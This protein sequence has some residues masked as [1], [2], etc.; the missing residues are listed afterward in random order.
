M[1]DFRQTVYTFLLFLSIG[2]MASG[3]Q[4]ERTV[5]LENLPSGV[6]FNGELGEK[7]SY[8]ESK[9]L[10][11]SKGDLTVTDR[12]ALYALS[13]DSLYRESVRRLFEWNQ[14]EELATKGFLTV[15]QDQKITPLIDSLA[16]AFNQYYPF[17]VIETRVS[18]SDDGAAQRLM[19]GEVR[20]AFMSRMLTEK[21]MDYFKEKQVVIAQ[22]LIARDAVCLVTHPSNP[23]DVMKIPDAQAALSGKIT[24]WKELGGE[25]KP[26]RLVINQE[27]LGVLKVVQDSL[28]GEGQVVK[29]PEV[30][31]SAMA[32]RRSMKDDQTALGITSRRFAYWALHSKLEDRDTTEF[33]GLKLLADSTNAEPIG[34]Y[35]YFIYKDFYPITYDVYAVYDRYQDLAN[36]L[37]A[38]AMV[39]GHPVF[40]N[41]GLMP[42]QVKV[43]VNP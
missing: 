32:F 42:M 29:E 23:I 18:D 9:Q 7:F 13:E 6:R 35:I 12:D 3:C 39:E 10:L 33:K 43:R 28:L 34:P 30:L 11:K 31:E 19:D 8:D 41:Q 15:S 2:F 4:P 5:D 26:I 17:G 37:A 1:R 22:H 14:A 16:V 38:F 20:L 24:N 25:D 36:G 40:K 21:E 27:A